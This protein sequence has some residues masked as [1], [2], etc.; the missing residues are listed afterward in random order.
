MVWV[1]WLAH[2]NPLSA[3]PAL[4]TLAGAYAGYS[5]KAI[6]AANVALRAKGGNQGRAL[7]DLRTALA[8]EPDAQRLYQQ[9]AL[10]ISRA[11]G[12]TRASPNP[13][14]QP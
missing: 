8:N 11:A 9:V 1:R 6:A 10:R 14:S 13:F 3:I 4:G 12:S 5:P 7:A 2:G